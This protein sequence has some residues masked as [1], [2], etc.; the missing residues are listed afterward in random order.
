MSGAT[1]IYICRPGQAIK[2]GR[3]EYGAIET[4]DEAQSDA[5]ERLR[6]DPSIGKIAYYAVSANGDFRCILTRTNPNARAP[7]PKRAATPPRPPPKPKPP[8]RSL[9]RRIL[10]LLE[11]D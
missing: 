8:R 3:V 2:D 9:L 10:S 6:I 5:E 11:E 1:E 4:R 7:E